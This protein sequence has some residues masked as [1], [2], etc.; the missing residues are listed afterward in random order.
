M[1]VLLK[2]NDK[3]IICSNLYILCGSNLVNSLFYSNSCKRNHKIKSA[4]HV[5]NFF[6]VKSA[7]NRVAKNKLSGIIRETLVRPNF[8][9][10]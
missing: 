6:Y 7:N 1:S 10:F 4:M 8:N 9:I 2:T 3:N 5:L